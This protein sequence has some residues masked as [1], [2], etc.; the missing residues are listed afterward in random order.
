M[1]ISPVIIAELNIMSKFV[2]KVVREDDVLA[3]SAL[4]MLRGGLANGCVANK[5][6]SFSGECDNNTCVTFSGICGVN[7]CQTDKCVGYQIVLP[8][9][10]KFGC[11]VESVEAKTNL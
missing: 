5:C 4:L 3:P 2:L 9:S 10:T 7:S 6:G 11:G 8:C 1:V